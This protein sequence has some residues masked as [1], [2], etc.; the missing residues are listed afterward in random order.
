MS[1]AA[2]KGMSLE[3]FFGPEAG[4]RGGGRATELALKK[5]KQV[6]AKCPVRPQCYETAKSLEWGVWGVWG[7]V[8]WRDG[9]PDE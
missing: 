6:C 5:G 3:L 7:G 2:C 9:V 4:S 1:Q 8:M